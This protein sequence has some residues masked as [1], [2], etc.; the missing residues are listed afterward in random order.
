MTTNK[1]NS[2]LHIEDLHFEH[3]QWIREL[4]FL[5]DELKFFVARLEEVAVRY[6]SMEVLKELEQFQNKIYIESNILDKLIHDTNEHEHQLA[7]Y[8]KENPIAIDR[9]T[10][11]DHSPLRERIERN[12]EMQIEFKRDYLR[13]L[14]KWL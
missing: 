3:A 9:V 13:F 1:T 10:F 11:D 14:A 12:R 4:K 2:N 7:R 6:T 8:A 5:K